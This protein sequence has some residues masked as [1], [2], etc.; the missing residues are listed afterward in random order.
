MR[1]RFMADPIMANVS[2][3]YRELAFMAKVGDDVYKGRIDLL[4]QKKD[5]SWHVVDHKTGNFQGQ[6]GEDKVRGYSDQ[7]RIYQAAIEQLV[8]K[9]VRS[10][11]YLV[12][13]Q[14]SISL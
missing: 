3:A 13:E 9:K 4:L 12:D 10:S 7:M 14:R 6:L 2:A 1:E 5:G 8:G 11:L